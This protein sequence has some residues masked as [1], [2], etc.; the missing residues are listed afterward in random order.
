MVIAVAH[1]LA[2]GVG[3]GDDVAC[4]VVR[5]RCHA[6]VGVRAACGAPDGVGDSGAH[7][8]DAAL[9][10]VAESRGLLV[11]LAAFFRERKEYI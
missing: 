11:L 7:H 5:R 8:G 9:G 2:G 10:D 1:R 3:D 4:G 6:G